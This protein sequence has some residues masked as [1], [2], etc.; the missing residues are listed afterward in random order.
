MG[1]QHRISSK[2]DEETSM[3]ICQL[4]NQSFTTLLDLEW[5][6]ET[7]HDARDESSQMGMKCQWCDYIATSDEA[8]DQ[9]KIANHTFPCDQCTL[10]FPS[11]DDLQEQSKIHSN[12]ENPKDIECR[13]CDFKA[14]NKQ[15]MYDH[16][17]CDHI[18]FAML[19]SVFSN[20][21]DARDNFEQFKGEL[22]NILNK[23]IDDQNVIK[24]EVFIV[25]QKKC[26]NDEVLSKM[27]KVLLDSEIIKQ[28]LFILRHASLNAKRT[29]QREPQAPVPGS[30][31]N[32]TNASSAAPVRSTYTLSAPKTAKPS[33]DTTPK[34]N[35][36][37]EKILLVGDSISGNIHVKTIETATKATVKTVKA[38]SA[39]YDDVENAAKNASRFPAKNFTVVI[40]E[41]L[42]KDVPD[43]LVIQSGS[44][45][46][47]NLKTDGSEA[48]QYMEYFKQ[49][50][51]VSSNTI[52]QAAIT[53]ANNHPKLKNVI[54]MKQI[55]RYDDD[56]ST[57]TGVKRKLS[58]MF[59][60]NL[61]KLWTDCPIKNKVMIGNHNLDCT[62]GIREARY[63]NIQLKKYD[64]LHMFGPSGTKSYTESVL[65]I[66]S[67]AQLVKPTPHKYYNVGTNL[68]NQGRPMN[69]RT[70][71]STQNNKMAASSTHYQNND[72]DYQYNVPTHS[73]FAKLSDFFPGN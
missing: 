4:C 62:G 8:N 67:S 63:R 5:H 68:K 70:H 50:A 54:I 2:Q 44:V 17:E 43:V 31:S 51:V 72:S 73:R 15:V 56:S 10:Q 46:I 25:R 19:A 69:R 60:A 9:H 22:T 66:L 29:P 65:S 42:S 39:A 33:K 38:Y 47:T 58:E 41:E 52:F 1:V 34:S 57:P 35:D 14:L 16:I 53:A 59:N 36:K 20:Q 32:R 6:E 48:V 37:V 27:Q 18:E 30:Q 3:R 23:I 12:N 64:A 21:A 7:E 11:T 13:Y 28:E 45:D 26:E 71:F 49:Q 61:D 55:P 24:Q 40:P